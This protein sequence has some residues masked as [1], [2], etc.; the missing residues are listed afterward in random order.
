MHKYDVH[1]HINKPYAWIVKILETTNMEYNIKI[2]KTLHKN[3]LNI[4]IESI[5]GNLNYV[6]QHG[7]S[8]INQK[9][10]KKSKKKTL[11]INVN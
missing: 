1:N 6:I 10:K 4:E 3:Y 2:L 8:S 7:F 5:N 9:K 11:L